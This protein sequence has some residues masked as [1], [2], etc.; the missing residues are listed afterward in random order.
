[1]AWRVLIPARKD[2]IIKVFNPAEHRGFH[3]HWAPGQVTQGRQPSSR[4]NGWVRM[5]RGSAGGHAG[6]PQGMPTGWIPEPLWL[7]GQQIWEQRGEA[8]WA[9]HE[10]RDPAQGPETVHFIDIHPG[11]VFSTGGFQMLAR[12]PAIPDDSIGKKF[13]IKVQHINP[14]GSLS[15]PYNFRVTGRLTTDRIGRLAQSSPKALEFETT[16]KNSGKIFHANGQEI[17]S[18]TKLKNGQFSVTQVDS[19]GR[20]HKFPQTFYTRR[21]AINAVGFAHNMQLLEAEAAKLPAPPGRRSLAEMINDARDSLMTDHRG[22]VILDLEG[23]L[24]TATEEGHGVIARHVQDMLHGITHNGV[25]PNLRRDIS[26]L[27]KLKARKKELLESVQDRMNILGSDYKGRI[28]RL[29]E[30]ISSGPTTDL[31]KPGS[32]VVADATIFHHQNGEK[33]VRK[34]QHPMINDA[35]EAA[36]LV[37][38]A[39]GANAPVIVRTSPT[40]IHVEFVNGPTASEAIAGAIPNFADIKNEIINSPAGQLLG[41]VDRLVSDGDRNNGNWII[42]DGQPVGIDRGGAF[43]LNFKTS[44]PGNDVLMHAWRTFTRHDPAFSVSQ[45]KE[46]RDQ[47]QL[48]EKVFRQFEGRGVEWSGQDWFD[49]MMREFDFWMDAARSTHPIPDPRKG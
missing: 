47:L 48:L 45:F 25:E 46:W 34:I 19:Q 14:N 37:A 21:S 36:S 30:T 10:W 5:Q 42:V 38:H 11:D 24:R 39:I 15:E 3:G 16:G 33:A 6:E 41:M 4:I 23:A 12:S 31:V 8:I 7:E 18:F 43:N 2:L 22:A 28:E 29:I 13:N 20:V 49:R 44:Q 35:E 1:M 40:E 26:Q 17:G 27:E 9:A 32:G